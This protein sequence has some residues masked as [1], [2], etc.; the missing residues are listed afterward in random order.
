MKRM[1]AFFIGHSSPMIAL[2]DN[3]VTHAWAAIGALAPHPRAI[4]AISA[5]WLTNGTAATAMTTPRTIHDF[6]AFPQALFE[7]Q[8]PAPGDPSLAS[9]VRDL[10][11]RAVSVL[12]TTSALPF[13]TMI[14]K[15]SS[16]ICTWV[17]MRV[18]RRPRLTIFGHCYRCWGRV[19]KMTPSALPL[20][21]FAMDQSV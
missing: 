20:T 3:D 1:P 9:R 8:Y 14:R 6:G 5:H 10:P 2:E 21:S 13:A 12:L 18:S 7:V 15:R 17:R 11:M 4:L 19:Q 16:T